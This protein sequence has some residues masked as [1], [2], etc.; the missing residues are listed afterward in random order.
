MQNHPTAR[1]MCVFGAVLGTL[2]SGTAAAQLSDTTQTPNTANAGIH[3]SL[4][5]Q[6]GA[7]RGDIMTPGSSLFIIAR[8]P[9]RSIRRG[10]QIF[11]RKFTSAQGQGPLTNDGVGDIETD[12]SIV[13]GLSDS[14]AGCHARPFGSAGFGG[15]VFTRPDSRDAPHL[16][17]LGL[18][19]MLADEITK[20]LRA[21]RDQA[22]ADAQGGGFAITEGLVSKGIHYGSITAFPD[23]TVDPSEIVGVNTDLRVRPFFAQGATISMREFIVGAFNAEMGL[24]S[25]DPDMLAAD[26][27]ADVVTP[28]GMELTGSIDDIEGPPVAHPMDDSDG[29]GVVNEIDPALVDHVE[30]YLL[31]YFKPGLE[32]QTQRVQKG[33]RVFDSIGCA[34][35]HIPDLTIDHDR[36][37][38]DIETAYDA[39]KSTGYFGNLFAD[40]EG[41]FSVVDDGSGFPALKQ[42]LGGSF[43]VRNIFTDFKRHD[44]GPEFHERNFDG[45]VQTKFMTEA[46][47]GVGSTPPYGHDGR[48]P[49]LQLVIMRHGGE[50]D[51]ARAR[52]ASLPEVKQRQLFSFLNSLVLFSPE[53]TPSTTNEMDVGNP[54]FPLAGHGSISLTPLFNDTSEI[55]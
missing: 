55:E 37:V 11:Q 1:G 51:F 40:I 43:L 30:F 26:G 34:E 18:Q 50:A 41:L 28:A 14:C 45:S 31:N 32:Q 10:R 13:A 7:G 35:C 24:E 9:A 27:G 4:T 21:I 47:W 38:A 36:R 23:G 8:D 42:P 16:F 15:D 53:D 22:V 54:D 20:E 25:P 44:L 12:P 39:S 49:T 48:S 2:F 17:G 5:E 3:K 33:R 46:L 19:E 52:F 6:V 29:D